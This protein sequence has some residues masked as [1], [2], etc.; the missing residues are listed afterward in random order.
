M[1][2]QNA[3]KWKNTIG[4]AGAGVTNLQA[5]NK[6]ENTETAQRHGITRHECVNRSASVVDC[7][8]SVQS[9]K[10]AHQPSCQAQRQVTV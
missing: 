4:V 1:Y 6:N 3:E 9:L 5:N 2:S 8:G 10:Y 7:C